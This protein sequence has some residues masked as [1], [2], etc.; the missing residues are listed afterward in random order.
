MKISDPSP[1]TAI[2][3]TRARP[4]KADASK[5]RKPKA[6]ADTATVMGIPEAELTPHVRAA[7]TALMEEVGR[8]REELRLTKA[9]I[10]DLEELAD[11]DALLPLINRRAFVR[12]LSRMMSYAERYGTPHTLIYFDLNGMKAINDTN[13]H[14]AGDAALI[15]VAGVL[16]ESTRESD[17]VGRLGGDEFGVLLAQADETTAHEK[18]AALA[19][20]ISAEGVPWKGKT[21]PLSVAFGVHPIRRGQDVDDAIQAADRAMYA[22]KAQGRRKVAAGG[23]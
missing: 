12:E 6:A 15:H 16:N 7:I 5:A 14:A 8:L 3:P 13:G 2:A 21:L 18:A 10:G 17:V 4:G 22:N 20:R 23:R 11:T 1:V 19:E 9:R